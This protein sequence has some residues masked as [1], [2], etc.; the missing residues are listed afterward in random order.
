MGQR[1]IEMELG[2]EPVPHGAYSL[3]YSIYCEH[4]LL[5]CVR[6]VL[7]SEVKGSSSS[8]RQAFVCGPEFYGYPTV[9]KCILYTNQLSVDEVAGIHTSSCVWDYN[10]VMSSP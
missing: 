7:V 2:S 10:A 6:T 4:R 8:L 1:Y 9:S 5:H 3:Q